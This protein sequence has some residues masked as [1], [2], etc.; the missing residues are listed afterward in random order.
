MNCVAASMIATS[1]AMMSTGSL[2][3]TGALSPMDVQ[4]PC[5]F[6]YDGTLEGLLSAVFA[7]CA[8]RKPGADLAVQGTIQ[9][10]LE[11]EVIVVPTDMDRALRIRRSLIRSHGDAAFDT[12]RTASASDDPGVGTAVYRFILHALAGPSGCAACPRKGSCRDVCQKP[13]YS[14]ILD[15]LGDPCVWPVAAASRAVLNERHRLEQFIR[16]KHMDGDVWFARCNP[17]ASVVPLLMDWFIPRFNTQRFVIFD[18]NHLLSGVYDGRRWYLVKGDAIAPPPESD[19]E[20]DME[21]AWR[22]FY[23]SVSIDERYN[24]ELRRSFMPM[25]L[26]RNITEVQDAPLSRRT[27]E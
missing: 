26:W 24:P 8:A 11:Q 17:N 27:R 2:A 14:A 6:S 10:R 16:F 25:R 12:I 19:D 22:T 7:A 21:E 23:D 3:R 20:H 13:R 18:E 5:L 15:D 9:P 1:A 4:T